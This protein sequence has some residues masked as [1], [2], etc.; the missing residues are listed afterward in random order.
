MSYPFS[1]L[2]L[3]NKPDVARA[4]EVA[5]IDWIF[6]DLEVRGKAERQPGGRTIISHHTLQDVASLRET[7]TNSRIVVRI[8]PMY[9]QTGHEIDAAL[10]AGGQAIMLPMASNREQAERFVDLVAGRAVTWLLIETIAGV[11]RADDIVSVSGIDWAHVG[12]NDLQ[13]S[14]HLTFMFEALAGGLIDLVARAAGRTGGK[15]NFGFG[16]IGRPNAPLPLAVEHILREH[17]RLGSHAAIL[18]RS[19]HGNPVSAEALH[20]AMDL[21]AEIKLLR[22]FI[23]LAAKRTPAETE[24]DRQRIRNLIW[25]LARR[26]RQS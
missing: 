26:T 12:L 5:G 9:E 21:P 23:D 22:D 6:V 16:A 25:Q 2:F 8:N 3:T 19:F 18:S 4:A 10:D 13:L 1:F 11:V 24:E 20:Q 7:L 15:P 14:S 17:V